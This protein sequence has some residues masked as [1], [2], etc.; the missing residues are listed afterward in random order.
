MAAVTSKILPVIFGTMPGSLGIPD[1]GYYGVTLSESQD[2]DGNPAFER[3]IIRYKNAKGTGT[4]RIIATSSG[5]SETKGIIIPTDRASVKEKQALEPGGVL[6]KNLRT[7]VDSI[8][9]NV[10]GRKSGE[11][12]SDYKKRR[13]AQKK[14][15]LQNTGGSGDPTNES[16]GDI[17]SAN[18]NPDKLTNNLN[19]TGALGEGKGRKKYPSISYP[20]TI[21]PRQDKLKISILKFSPKKLQGLKFA[22]RQ[23]YNKRILGSVILPTPGAI[24]DGNNVSW[25]QGDMNPGQ[26]AASDVLLNTM[27]G[28]TDDGA[29]AAGRFIDGIQGGTDDAKSA[30]AQFFTGQATGVK[31]ILARTEGAVINPNMELLFRTPALRPFNFTYKMSPRDEPESQIVLEIIRMFKQ[32]MAAQRTKSELFLRAPN[33]YNLKFIS[34]SNQEHNYLPKIKECA[35]KGF[36]VNYTPDGQYNTFSNTSMV[37]YELQFQFQ[38]LEPIFNDDYGNMSGSSKDTNIGF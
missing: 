19:A 2:T 20:E 1:I 21:N 15:A 13:K 30:V 5:T 12:W 10:L 24:S 36:T 4:Q 27:L 22:D 38:E 9:P 34:G 11:K 14:K 32:S 31:G 33:T 17:Q 25:S 29:D 8:E 23:N 28:G 26:V 7:A 18:S 16:Q 37:S 3:S 6:L 35:L